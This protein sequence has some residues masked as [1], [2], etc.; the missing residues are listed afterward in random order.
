MG[1]SVLAGAS[2]LNEIIAPIGLDVEAT[3]NNDAV[4]EVAATLGLQGQASAQ[5][6]VPADI[7]AVVRFTGNVEFKEPPAVADIDGFLAVECELGALV[8]NNAAVCDFAFDATLSGLIHQDNGIV[9]D[10]AILVDVE[11]LS[12]ISAGVGCGIALSGDIIA[13]GANEIV[14]DAAI[15]VLGSRITASS[16]DQRSRI[17]AEIGLL[18]EIDMASDMEC[19]FDLYLQRTKWT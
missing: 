7:D 9:S 15:S 11:A 17:N 10:I 13:A 6:P 3:G 12:R 2:Q 8:R 14:I 19:S 16:A 18:A 4:V 1:V 5:I